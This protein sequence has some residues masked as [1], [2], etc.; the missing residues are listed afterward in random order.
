MPPDEVVPA[1]AEGVAPVRKKLVGLKETKEVLDAVGNLGA[2]ITQY[3]KD[4]FQP[5]TDLPALGIAIMTRP[6]VQA[7][8]RAAAEGIEKVPGELKDVDVDECVELSECGVNITK[9]IVSALRN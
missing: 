2:L 8:L 7:S 6:D 9:K 1:G 5:G 3:L 4:G